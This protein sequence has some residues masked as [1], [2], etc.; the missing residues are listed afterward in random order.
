MRLHR[1]VSRTI[2]VAALALAAPAALAEGYVGI[3]GGQSDFELDQSAVR[4]DLDGTSYKAFGGFKFKP[5]IAA[6]LQYAQFDGLES[7]V[8]E[9]GAEFDGDL[10]SAF[11]VVS[12]RIAPRVE[13][14]AKAGGTV[15]DTSVRISVPDEP[16]VPVDDD[17]TEFSYGLGVGFLATQHFGVRVEWETFG[18]LGDAKSVKFISV[19]LQYTF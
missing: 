10:I 4:F 1:I 17:G 7:T 18:D 2:V 14:W 12:A 11:V 15:W 3:S 9:I 5:W 19:G 6:E 8:G 16:T 13:V